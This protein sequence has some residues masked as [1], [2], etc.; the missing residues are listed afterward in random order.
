M[1]VAQLID[2]DAKR[3]KTNNEVYQN[4]YNACAIRWYI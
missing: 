4:I 3:T 2:I 1:T